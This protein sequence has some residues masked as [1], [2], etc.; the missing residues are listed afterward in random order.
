[1][2]KPSNEGVQ[3]IKRCPLSFCIKC[4]GKGKHG[5]VQHL[6]ENTPVRRSGM[7]HVLK[8]SQFYLHT[9]LSFANR[10]NHTCIRASNARDLD[11]S[12]Q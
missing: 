1:M 11:I 12:I 2:Y 3:D 4:K 9:P 8:G 6:V 7:A 5:F 10:M